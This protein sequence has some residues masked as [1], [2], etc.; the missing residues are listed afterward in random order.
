MARNIVK[1]R[2]YS[3]RGL[4]RDGMDYRIKAAIIFAVCLIVTLQATAQ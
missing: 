1:T 3:F 4:K 2:D